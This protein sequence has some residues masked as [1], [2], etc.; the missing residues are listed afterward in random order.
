MS[1]SHDVFIKYY[2][3]KNYHLNDQKD[4]FQSTVVCAFKLLL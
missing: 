2:V 3:V 4:F 1:H